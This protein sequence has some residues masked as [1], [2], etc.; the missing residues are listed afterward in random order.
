MLG[1]RVR[2]QQVVWNLLNNAVNFTPEG[3]AIHLRLESGDRVPLSIADTGRG[4]EPELLPFI[5]ERFRQEEE[6]VTR[7]YDGLGLGLAIVKHLVEQHGGRVTAQSPGRGRGATFWVDLPATAGGPSEAERSLQSS[8][9]HEPAIGHDL[10]GVRALV[11]DDDEDCREMVAFQLTAV[12]ANVRI[13]TSAQQA[14]QFFR[15]EVPV[16][17]VSDIAMPGEDGLD[18]ARSLP[19]SVP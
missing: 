13:A 11:V 15:E 8:P 10:R 5:F 4:V 2:L 18:S 7:R 3:G 14:L 19:E 12:G 6:N 9:R 16:V 1:D 17:L